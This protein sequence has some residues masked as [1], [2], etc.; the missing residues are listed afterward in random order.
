MNARES[1]A[2]AAASVRLNGPAAE[3]AEAAGR[4]EQPVVA[5]DPQRNLSP[6]HQ[7]DQ[8]VSFIGFSISH[9]FVTP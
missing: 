6:N 5:Q 3:A 8:C 1:R 2:A 9:T 4:F 7:S